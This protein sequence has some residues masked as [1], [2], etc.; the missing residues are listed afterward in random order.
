[1][2]SPSGFVDSA[3][4]AAPAAAISASSIS[5]P[6]VWPMLAMAR[7][8]PAASACSRPPGKNALFSR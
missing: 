2:S 5:P 3:T 4:T 1:M 7:L 8:R 6:R